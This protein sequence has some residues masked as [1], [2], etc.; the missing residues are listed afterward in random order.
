M[1]KSHLYF[2]SFELLVPCPLKTGQFPCLLICRG[3]Y[4]NLHLVWLWVANS[5]LL[6]CCLCLWRSLT[7]TS[8]K[9]NLWMYH[10]S[11]P[12]KDVVSVEMNF[13]LRRWN[14]LADANNPAEKE[15]TA[16]WEGLSA[17]MTTLGEGVRPGTKV[18]QWPQAVPQGR[19]D[20]RV[21]A[22]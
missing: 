8:F 3:S 22:L 11:K 19:Q 7:C 9:K 18:E 1:C 15:K 20:P 6:V 14:L 17:G 16:M 13:L 5:F 10:C 4:G 21:L 2:L 12:L